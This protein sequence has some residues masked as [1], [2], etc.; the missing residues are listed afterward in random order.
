MKT[1][2]A[3]LI[4]VSVLCFAQ[5]IETKETASADSIDLHALVA[6]QISDAIARQK[7][8]ELNPKLE[9]KHITLETNTTQKPVEREQLKP[10]QAESSPFLSVLT[11]VPW[12]YKVFAFASAV[13]LGLV[14]TRRIVLSFARSSKKALKK[15]IGLMRE[16][17]IG[18]SKENPKLAKVRKSL[19]DNLDMLK[20]PDAKIGKKAK[21]LN[22]SKGELLLAARLKLF[23]VGKL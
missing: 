11:S 7:Q 3:I 12:Q 8:D 17:K 14:F 15:K 20:Q 9:E 23:E 2:L 5:T 22:I 18:G 10:V 13:L 19:K 16:E 21:Q 6:K 4:F 1:I